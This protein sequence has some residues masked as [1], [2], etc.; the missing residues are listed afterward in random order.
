MS[1]N[2]GI[3]R[4]R[5][6]LLDTDHKQ[7][8]CGMGLYD[9]SKVFFRE[10]A[11]GKVYVDGKLCRIVTNAA[12]ANLVKIGDRF[13][14]FVTIGDQVWLAENLE[15]PF[16]NATY[17]NGDPAQSYGLLYR[18]RDMESLNF[19]L[20]EL[21]AGF[22]V[23]TKIEITEL[24]EAAGGLSIA[25]KNLK[26]PDSWNSGVGLDLYGFN[27]KSAGLR[28]PNNYQYKGSNASMWTCVPD[29]S[30]STDSEWRASVGVGDVASINFLAWGFSAPVRLVKDTE[31]VEIAGRQYHTARM[32]DYIVMIENL[33][34]KLDGIVIGS[35]DTPNTPAAWYYNNDEASETAANNGLLYNGYCI[36]LINAAAP[37]GWHVPTSVEMQAIRVTGIDDA[38]YSGLNM[39]VQAAGGLN[40]I[41]F[42]GALVGTRNG[43]GIFESKNVL[44]RF[45]LDTTSGTNR[46]FITLQQNLDNAGIYSVESNRAYSIRLVKYD[47]VS[48]SSL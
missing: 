38:S 43:S 4:V 29:F 48:S 47:P 41:R 11:D 45:W 12:D 46:S 6:K 20:L 17:Y 24:V 9:P 36:D 18:G 14:K 15:L 33:D 40:A 39:K 23:P 13:Y 19:K 10:D 32:G 25:G 7:W 26:S 16:D 30:T 27:L 1:K 8:N 31:K 34:A 21:D 44:G 28:V 42:N 5:T 37:D 3:G 22:H 35:N 2:I